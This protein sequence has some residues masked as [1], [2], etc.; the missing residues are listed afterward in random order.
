MKFIQVLEGADGESARPVVASGD[1]KLVAAV[2]F[3]LSRRLGVP[4]TVQQ[5]QEAFAILDASANIESGGP[6]Q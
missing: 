2:G 5:V 6:R 4:N 3:L 1:A